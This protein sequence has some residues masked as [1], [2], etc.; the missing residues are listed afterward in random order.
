MRYLIVATIVLATMITR[1][2]PLAAQATQLFNDESRLRYRPSPR[3]R[4]I[5]DIVFARYGK[6]ALRLDLYLPI[7]SQAATPGVIVIRGGG[8][9]V[10]D[11][12]DFAH[13]ASALAERG[14]AAANIE[15]RTAA[16]APY[17]GAVQDVKAAIRW[18]RA[19][20]KLYGISPDAIGTS[21]TQHHG[22][23]SSA[24]AVFT[25]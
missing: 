18:M 21:H 16:E 3:V 22:C 6:R 4:V 24:G 23:S 11:R 1:N 20:A 12:A 10:N 7:L 9:M 25:V 5:T 15:Y 19:N 14:L 17:P 13:V 8:W 2:E